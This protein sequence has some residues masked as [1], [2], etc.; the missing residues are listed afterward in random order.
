MKL[1]R[2]LME[3]ILSRQAV[4][5]L[6][7]GASRAF[8]YPSWIEM[9]ENLWH[10]V[11]EEGYSLEEERLAQYRAKGNLP[12]A[13]DYIESVIGREHMVKLIKKDFH[14]NSPNSQSIYDI[15]AKWP[16]SCYCTTNYDHEIIRHLKKKNKSFLEVG[17]KK[18]DFSNIHASMKNFVFQLHGNLET[19]DRAI[20]TQSDYDKLVADVDFKYYQEGLKALFRMRKCILIGYGCEDEDIKVILRIVRSCIN[21][22]NNT[23]IFLADV[24]DDK[25]NELTNRFALTVINYHTRLGSHD[26]LLR[27]LSMMDRFMSG[28]KALP[29]TH[30]E[31]SEKAISLYLCGT[32]YKNRR[33]VDFSNYILLNMKSD[34]KGEDVGT[35]ASRLHVTEAEIKSGVQ[36]LLSAD[37]VEN[38][39]QSEIKLTNKGEERIDSCQEVLRRQ[40]EAAYGDFLKAMGVSS[41]EGSSFIKLAEDVLV[42]IFQKRGY[43]LTQN[44]FKQT[45]FTSGGL[46]DVYGILAKYASQIS[47]TKKMLDFVNA[48]HEFVITPTDFQKAYLTGLSQGYFLYY[49]IGSD[50]RTADV[51]KKIF[52][53]TT[54]Y[55]DSNV[56]IP[57]LAKGCY[58]HG[59]SSKLFTLLKRLKAQLLVTPGVLEEVRWHLEWARKHIMDKKSVEWMRYATLEAGNNLNLF[60]DGFIHEK[61]SGQVASFDS[62]CYAIESQLSEDGKKIASTYGLVLQKPD[63]INSK[64]EQEKF[65]NIFSEIKLIRDRAN[66]YK[67]D[68]QVRTEAEIAYLANKRLDLAALL[69]ADTYVYFLSQSPI[70]SKIEKKICVWT[71]EAL[72]R[73]AEAISARDSTE[74]DDDLFHACLLGEA[75]TAGEA[76]IDK[77]MYEAFFKEEIDAATR[78]FKEEVPLYVEYLEASVSEEEMEGNFMRLPPLERPSAVNRLSIHLRQSL[79]KIEQSHKDEIAERDQVIQVKEDKIKEYQRAITK[80]ILKHSEEIA[81][82]DEEN[83]K[84]KE[85]NEKKDRSI[86]A[87]EATV[88]NLR[89][90]KKKRSEHKKQNKRSKR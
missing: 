72:F 37:L 6:G 78:T 71:S 19:D 44:I 52:E 77:E 47:D 21:S 40:K 53:K 24:S 31:D 38:V 16:F 54:W 7:A 32:M 85:D 63:V 70:L 48:I 15:I 34:G 30:T 59:Y 58:L 79:G 89:N 1:N 25:I 23:Y 26:E 88:R 64:S 65:D 20:I 12:E 43:N 9:L 22:T 84:L 33:N 76:F 14:A 66:T 29:I 28:S 75:F 3:A 80:S 4:L 90:K 86:R 51:R 82:R 17:N 36:I 56:L 67:N 18:K 50:A 68:H 42:Q 60:I 73:Y 62:Y 27:Y 61:A 35:L 55:V 57:L 69:H 83:A 10:R 74:D 5:F 39:G 81:K 41:K 46:L 13:F 8:G 49:L 2:D 11:N 87:L 45:D